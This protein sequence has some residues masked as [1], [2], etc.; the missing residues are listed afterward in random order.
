MA[1]ATHGA[2]RHLGL[3]VDNQ[4]PEPPTAV[5]LPAPRRPPKRRGLGPGFQGIR[6][7]H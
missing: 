7:A 4:E 6:T 2:R 1:A 5:T 3:A